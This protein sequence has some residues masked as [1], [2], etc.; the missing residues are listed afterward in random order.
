MQ[1]AMLEQQ[2]YTNWNL[3]CIDKL[4]T[5]KEIELSG[6]YTAL[7]EAG[8]TI[9]PDAYTS[10]P[11]PLLF[12]KRQSSQEFTGK[13]SESRIWFIRMKMSDVRMNQRQRRQQSLF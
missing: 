2:S 12:Q 6:E 7:I 8:D 3:T 5:G 10:L 4:C 11:M 1:L 13:K 9:E